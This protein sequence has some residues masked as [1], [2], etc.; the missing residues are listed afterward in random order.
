MPISLKA[1]TGS[2]NGMRL[3]AGQTWQRVSGSSND[4]IGSLGAT[5]ININ[6]TNTLLS[7]T[8]KYTIHY[9]SISG[10]SVGVPATITLTIDGVVV[11]SG[12]II[13]TTA[14]V[15]NILGSSAGD[16]TSPVS[17]INSLVL[18]AQSTGVTDLSMSAKIFAEI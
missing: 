1:T 6:T 3:A 9:L 14:T 4:G 13:P 16:M 5:G 18:T 17:V 11:F 10:L 15:T 2:G 8:G 7:L 12:T